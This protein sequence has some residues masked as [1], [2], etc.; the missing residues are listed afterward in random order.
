MKSLPLTFQI[1]TNVLAIHVKT[2]AP[3][4]I[5]T[6]ATLANALLDSPGSIAKDSSPSECY[7]EVTKHLNHKY[8]YSGL[9]ERYLGTYLILQRQMDTDKYCL[10]LVISVTFDKLC[11]CWTIIAS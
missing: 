2:E 6:M 3:V 1:S 10:C 11:N 8:C 9:A 4:L 7:T 5:C